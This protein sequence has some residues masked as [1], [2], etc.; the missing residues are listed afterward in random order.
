MY[1]RCAVAAVLVSLVGCYTPPET[2]R[3]AEEVSAME[4]YRDRERAARER[5]IAAL[6]ERA[7]RRRAA[8]PRSEP[9]PVQDGGGLADRLADVL[10]MTDCNIRLQDAARV[11]FYAGALNRWTETALEARFPRKRSAGRV[12]TYI[13]DAIEFMDEDRSWVRAVYECDYDH[14]AG[15]VADV[16][17]APGRLP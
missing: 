15:E 16:R 5:R 12:T 14:D 2:Y 13:G 10:A 8:Q 9:A 7:A 6:E 11:M 1:A 17:S 4:D 3:S